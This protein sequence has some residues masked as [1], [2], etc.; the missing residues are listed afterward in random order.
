MS[1]SADR[2]LCGLR[3]FDGGWGGRTAGGSWRL[4]KD[5]KN[6]GNELGEVLCYQQNCPENELK[7]N[8]KMT[9]KVQPECA[10]GLDLARQ[11]RSSRLGSCSDGVQWIVLEFLSE[12]GPSKT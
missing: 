8:S 12:T 2:R 7:T 3:L 6:R 5:V 10:N 1:C 11:T 9:A 4:R